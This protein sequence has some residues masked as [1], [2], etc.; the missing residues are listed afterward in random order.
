MQIL[1]NLLGNAT[2]FTFDGEICLKL[3]LI[4]CTKDLK[5][6]K[7]SVTDTGIGISKEN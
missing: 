5:H 3:S 7:F 1:N 6:V 4:T 2:K